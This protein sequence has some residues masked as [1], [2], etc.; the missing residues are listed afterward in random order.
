[1]CQIFVRAN[2]QSYEATT[3]SI[4]LHGVVTSVRLENLFWD[5]LEEIAQRDA[6]HVPQ[7]LSKLYDE[8][9]EHRGDIPNF[10]SF[11][12]VCCLRYLALQVD[13]R[14]PRDIGIPIGSLN[15]HAVLRGLRPNLV[16]ANAA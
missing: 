1:M 8:L 6:M 14:I 10:S 4:R 9:L 16:D 12:R 7:L 13:E 15:A 3:R 2:A 5:T 11:L